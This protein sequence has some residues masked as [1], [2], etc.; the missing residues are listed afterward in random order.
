MTKT[1]IKLSPD[2]LAALTELAKAEDATVE[3]L[4]T[5]LVDEAFSYRLLQRPAPIEPIF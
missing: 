4:I 5:I 3:A 1:W 2:M